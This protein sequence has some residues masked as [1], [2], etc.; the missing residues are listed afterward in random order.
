MNRDDAKVLALVVVN[1]AAGEGNLAAL[2]VDHVVGSCDVLLQR[3][4]IG[5]Q[6]EDRARLVYVTDRVVAQQLRRG[7]AKVIGVERGADGQ[8][9]N[10]AGMHVLHYHSAVG[11]LSARHGV[12]QRL[13][14]HEL[15]VLVN[16]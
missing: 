14:G 1:D 6:L 4:R 16:G 13:L 12:V 11:R 2:A 8:G 7:V 5:D 3:R 15:D 10:L 9:Q